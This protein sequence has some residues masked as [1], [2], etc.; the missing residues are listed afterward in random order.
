MACVTPSLMSNTMPVVRPDAYKLRITGAVQY[1]AGG[2]QGFKPNLCQ[3]DP[4]VRLSHLTVVT[5][6][7]N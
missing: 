2:T 4:I 1:K 5:A 3:L 7:L 6:T